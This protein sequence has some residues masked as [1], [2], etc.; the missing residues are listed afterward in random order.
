MTSAET[1]TAYIGL[2]SNLRS[3]AGTPAE[4]IEAAIRELERIGKVTARS[5]LYETAPVGLTE[6]PSF[7]NAVVSFRTSD[8]PDNFLEK[9][10]AIERSFGRDRKTSTPKGPRTLDLDLLLV[11]ELVVNTPSLSLPHPALADRR[12]VLAPLAE[13][14]PE[15]QHPVLNKSMRDLLAA[16]PNDGANSIDRVRILPPHP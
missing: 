11:D 4:T 9:L 7:I 6:Q 13:I 16:L 10:L 14:C 5:S 1:H 3:P 15:L 2:G 8:Q 12:F